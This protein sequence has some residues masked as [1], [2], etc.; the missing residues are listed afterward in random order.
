MAINIKNLEERIQ[1]KAYAVTSNTPTSELGDIVEAALLATNSLREYDS[2]DLLPTAT[3]SNEKLAYVKKDNS[4]RFNNGTKW[5]SLVSGAA[6]ATVPG[7][8]APPTTNIQALTSIYKAGG[9]LDLSPYATNSIEKV[10]IASDGNATDVGDISNTALGNQ[11]GNSGPDDGFASGG[12]NQ[13]PTYTVGGGITQIDKYPFATDA[14][15]TDA[16]DI[17]VSRGSA[18]TNNS[19]THGYQTGG[20]SGPGDRVNSISKFP[21][22]IASGTGT[23]VGDIAPAIAPNG[24]SSGG[25]SSDTTHAY[26]HGGYYNL[27]WP[28][29][30]IIQRF[31]FATDTNA[32]DVGDMLTAGIYFVTNHQQSTTHGYVTAGIG[33]PSSPGR[34]NDITKFPFAASGANASDVGDATVARYGAIGG[35][36]T[37]HGYIMGGN[38]PSA[39]TNVIDKYSTSSDANAT[40]VGDLI[41]ATDRGAGG[42]V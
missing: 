20:A 28:T 19:P 12:R 16:G 2:A 27:P 32:E 37:S 31:P 18:A 11:M 39:E 23:D 33:G 24:M 5:D 29:T 17:L 42:Q 1:K 6:Q 34:K 36:S 3:S 26:I 10:S 35:S 21:Y 15:S 13:A 8:S 9:R 30:N 22:A 38:T 41:T 40:D 14:N 7:P 4:I 25:G